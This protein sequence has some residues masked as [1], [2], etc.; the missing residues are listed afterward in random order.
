MTHARIPVEDGHPIYLAP[1][2]QAVDRSGPCFEALL[3]RSRQTQ[4]ER[5]AV[6]AQ[7][8]DL[9]GRVVADLGCGR[10]DLAAWLAD[11]GVEYGRYIGVDGVPEMIAFSQERAARERLVE[12]EFLTA[13]FA[14]DT[15]FFE[16]LARNHN[17]DC[18][19]FSGSL[20]TMDQALAEV[21]L[22][23]AWRA[24]ARIRGQLVFNFLSDRDGGFP[25]CEVDEGPARRFDTLRMVR[26]ALDRTTRVVFRH[27][28]L[29]G[30]DATIGMMP[31][32]SRPADRR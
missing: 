22:D 24:M 14:A 9:V 21:V 5:F 26:W 31:A 13:D 8:A 15:A 4:A 29:D 16:G 28:Y 18:L 27:D 2:A 7:T 23:R 3:W 11:A 32:F 12:C 19:V 17:V 10:G 6:I 30:Q 1:Y 20:N 25:A